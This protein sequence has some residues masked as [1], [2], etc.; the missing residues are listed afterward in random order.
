MHLPRITPRRSALALAPAPAPVTGDSPRSEGQ[1]R[2]V[3]TQY[4]VTAQDVYVRTHPMGLAVGALQRGDTVTV[5]DWNKGWA[6]GY[7]NGHADRPGWM[8][9]GPS[10][11]R[12]HNAR[13]IEDSHRTAGGIANTPTSA[14]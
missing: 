1:P 9:L 2:R 3:G 5:L 14:A 13:R 11:G 4:E 12:G 10:Q 7:A 8:L 6:Y